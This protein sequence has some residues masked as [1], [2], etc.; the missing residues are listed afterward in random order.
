MRN[1]LAQH[2][3]PSDETY[4][5]FQ[6]AFDTFNRE[7]FD[8]T[9]PP[10]LLTLQRKANTC[11]YL[12][13]NRF[14]NRSGAMAH[15]LA[16]NPEWFA[17]SPLVEILQTLVHEMVHL[18]Q[19][20][21]GKPGRARFHN[22]EWADKMESI[23]L[24]PSDTGRPGGKRTGDCMSDYAIEGGRFLQVVQ[25]LLDEH[26]F[27]I[28]WYDRFPPARPPAALAPLVVATINGVA[29]PEAATQIPAEHGVA[30]IPRP[31]TSVK[32]SSNRMKYSCPGCKVSVWGKPPPHASEQKPRGPMLSIRC[33][34]CEMDF[35]PVQLA[36]ADV[37][38]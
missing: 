26:D 22:R 36:T 31:S 35:E 12:S 14:A 16:M 9:L 38:D 37:D 24:M 32:N 10:V 21:H 25:Q 17:I 34:N 33:N 3:T 1:A 19:H 2:H 13:P 4:P 20:V 27:A 7:L 30:T 11:G 29:M 6:F 5:P 8:G 28:A 15:E 23:G 18:W